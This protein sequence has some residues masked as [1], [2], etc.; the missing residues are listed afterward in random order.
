[1]SK[2]LGI[3]VIVAVVAALLTSGAYAILCGDCSTCPKVCAMK[4]ASPMCGADAPKCDPNS[5]PKCGADAPKCDPNSKP[6]PKCGK[7][8]PNAPKCGSK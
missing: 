4:S 1:M 3:A 6:A 5:K 2:K 8:D 7:C